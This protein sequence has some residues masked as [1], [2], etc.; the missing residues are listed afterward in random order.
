MAL[1]K[2]LQTYNAKL[3]ELREH[4]GKFVLIHGSDIVDY[5]STYDDAIKE[6]YQ[7]FGLEPFLVKQIQSLEQVQLVS[8]L[9]EPVLVRKASCFAIAALHARFLAGVPNARCARHGVRLS[10]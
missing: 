9:A 4:E 2:E 5:F 1:E 6:G 8:R 7:K 10:H 3:A